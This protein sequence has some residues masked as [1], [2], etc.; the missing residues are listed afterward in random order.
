MEM[1]ISRQYFPLSPPAGNKPKLHSF[2][3]MLA[4]PHSGPPEHWKDPLLGSPQLCCPLLKLHGGGQPHE[5][6]PP[7]SSIKSNGN[8]EHQM[9]AVLA[10]LGHWVKTM[11]PQPA[12]GPDSDSVSVVLVV[13][14]A[15]AACHI[16]CCLSLAVQLGSSSTA[17]HGA[18]HP[19]NFHT[20]AHLT[21]GRRILSSLNAPFEG[22]ETQTHCQPQIVQSTPYN[23]SERCIGLT[24]AFS[25]S[26]ILMGPEK[27]ET[28]GSGPVLY[29][30][31]GCAS[32]TGARTSPSAQS[33]FT[34]GDGSKAWAEVGYWASSSLAVVHSLTSALESGRF[35]PDQHTSDQKRICTAKLAS[36]HLMH[37]TF[38]TLGN[39]NQSPKANPLINL[40]P[41]ARSM[42][43]HW[44]V[45]FSANLGPFPSELLAVL[46]TPNSALLSLRVSKGPQP[47]PQALKGS[48]CVCQKR[49]TGSSLI[50]DQH[51]P[52]LIILHQLVVRD[53][54]SLLKT[55]HCGPTAMASAYCWGP[56]K[57]AHPQTRREENA[58]AGKKLCFNFRSRSAF[59][60]G[61]S[62]E[63]TGQAGP[64]KAH[65]SGLGRPNDVRYRARGTRV[66]L[67]TRSFA[68]A[69]VRISPNRGSGTVGLALIEAWRVALTVLDCAVAHITNESGKSHD[70]CASARRNTFK[71]TLVNQLLTTTITRTRTTLPPIQAVYRQTKEARNSKQAS[72]LTQNRFPAHRPHYDLP[73]TQERGGVTS[74]CDSLGTPLIP[75]GIGSSAKPMPPSH[76][77]KKPVVYRRHVGGHESAI[78]TPTV[79]PS[80]SP[81]GVPPSP[82]SFAE[83]EQPI[84]K[85][86]F[87][88]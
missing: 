41:P 16:Y 66:T 55:V 52:S 34:N 29:S 49:Q 70:G 67:V 86:R 12:C 56:I 81:M 76:W 44:V 51:Q 54:W 83:I 82:I 68:R 22:R 15:A 60:S 10:T 69:T 7:E 73:R 5:H 6:S 45:S 19:S 61:L 72:F 48:P 9:L 84:T 13:V 26:Q 59:S 24:A 42:T 75:T 30:K 40:H 46:H 3:T 85:L 21:G 25:S 11:E 23:P 47:P 18:L 28:Q 1:K 62:L 57:P 71:R 53:M 31:A 20:A 14:A 87:A 39:W 36:H 35:R 27:R 37:G 63:T 77:L 65:Q 50:R 78:P 74:S 79:C 33:H 43:S 80:V 38:F 4:A 2:Q 88:D 58:G 64:S 17:H 8:P 32:R